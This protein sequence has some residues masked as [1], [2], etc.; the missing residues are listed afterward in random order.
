MWTP[1]VILTPTLLPP[2]SQSP[3]LPSI[4][5]SPLS[6]LSPGTSS[7]PER[8]DGDLDVALG[9]VAPVAERVGVVHAL[10]PNAVAVV[11]GRRV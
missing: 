6:V 9:V 4:H 10:A 11:D 7:T 5:L 3:Q 1:Y 8:V 2:L